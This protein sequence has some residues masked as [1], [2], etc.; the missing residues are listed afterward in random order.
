MLPDVRHGVKLLL[1][2]LAGEL[3]LGVAV[4]DLVV[5]VQRP[6]LFEGLAA[7]HALWEE[8]KKKKTTAFYFG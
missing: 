6:Q 3:L 2:D 5:L 4:D 7:R 8:K 1:T